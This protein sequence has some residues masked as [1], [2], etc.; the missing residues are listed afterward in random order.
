MTKIYRQIINIDEEK[1]IGCTLCAQACNEGAIAMVNGKAKLIRDDYC[2]GLGNC[3]PACPTG[4]ISF[5]ERLADPFDKE[6]VEAKMKREAKA[7]T[8]LP[9]A[10]GCPGSAS[11]KMRTNEISPCANTGVN[12][13]N[14]ESQLAQWPVQ[15][16]L[17]PMRAG[18][19]DQA[20]LLVAAD[21][22]AF[23]YGN[24]HEDFMKNRVTIIG[25]PKLDEGSYAGKLTEILKQND[26]KSLTIVRME[27]PCCGGLERAAHEAL[28][29]CDKMIPWQTV[30]LSTDGRVLE[31]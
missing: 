8:S 23:S 28:R 18:F 4:A 17:V 27:V 5:E 21:C 22:S 12:L 14:T 10:S 19:F 15:M 31:L 11:R 24:F 25:C 20:H 6:A 29:A 1:C 16:K 7:R 26:I 3:L 2:D 13:G 9:Q 30:T